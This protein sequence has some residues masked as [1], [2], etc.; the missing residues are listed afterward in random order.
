[1]L[2]DDMGF[3]PEQDVLF[4]LYCRLRTDFD[5]AITTQEFDIWLAKAL[6]TGLVDDEE[7]FYGDFLPSVIDVITENYDS[8]PI[9]KGNGDIPQFSL[10]IATFYE[11]IC[12]QIYELDLDEDFIWSAGDAMCN[13]GAGYYKGTL[14]AIG[15]KKKA[16]V[17]YR[18]AIELGN[19]QAMINLGYLYQRGW[20][21]E[22]DFDKAFKYYAK[23][24]ILDGNHPEVCYRL[25]DMYYWGLGVEADPVV[26]FELYLKAKFN[27]D[28]D[29]DGRYESLLPSILKR[30]AAGFEDEATQK[31]CLILAYRSYQELEAY[32]LT[33][34]DDRE[35]LEDLLVDL[36][37][38]MDDLRNELM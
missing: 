3:G 28:D 32:Y 33:T 20:F 14:A 6:T 30:M 5:K 7:E 10:S 16:I 17:C 4:D 24:Y 36:H 31:H 18:K 35:L 11:Y 9:Y 21:V 23:A 29:E 37:E 27:L 22:K 2:Y 1:M 19:V 25:G 8:D 34:V 12:K 13:L 15:D 26:G 38:K